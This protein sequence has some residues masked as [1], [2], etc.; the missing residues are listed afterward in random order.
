MLGL[1]P[2]NIVFEEN[3]L[4]LWISELNKTETGAQKR[5]QLSLIC[6]PNVRIIRLE[7]S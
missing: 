6:F 1:C 5:Q 4:L 3:F 7:T 2:F